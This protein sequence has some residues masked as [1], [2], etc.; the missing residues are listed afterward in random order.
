MT[1]SR[2]QGAEPAVIEAVHD[3]D[4]DGLLEALRIK[5]RLERGELLCSSCRLPV[6]RENLNTIFASSGVVKVS[7]DR[8]TCLIEDSETDNWPDADG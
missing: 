6:T 1:D 5:T 7:C 8:P 3:D 4:L 2:E